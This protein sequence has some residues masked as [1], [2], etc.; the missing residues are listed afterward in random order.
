MLIC[1]L[2]TIVAQLLNNRSY[3]AKSITTTLN[4]SAPLGMRPERGIE[5]AEQASMLETAANRGGLC[6]LELDEL[7][8]RAT[9]RCDSQRETCPGQLSWRSR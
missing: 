8:S 4:E 3:S 9:C 1:N 5:Q 2:Y 6:L 7:E